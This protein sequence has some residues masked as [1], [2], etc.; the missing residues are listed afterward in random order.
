M[1]E[2]WFA[3]KLQNEEE[4][5]LVLAA[6]AEVAGEYLVLLKEDGTTAA[7]FLRDVVEDWSSIDSRPM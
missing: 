2:S 6:T 5:E 4:P 7:L 3:V 1:A